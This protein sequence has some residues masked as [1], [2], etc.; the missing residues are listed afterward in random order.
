MIIKKKYFFNTLAIAPLVVFPSLVLTACSLETSTKYFAEVIVSGTSSILKDKS[1]NQFAYEGWMNFM[2]NK[3][4]KNLYGDLETY[5]LDGQWT[6]FKGIPDINSNSTDFLQGNGLWRRGGST[7]ETTL[8][9]I[10]KGGANLVITPGF[11]FQESVQSV[12]KTEKNKGF[13]LL[14]GDVDNSVHDYFNVSTFSFRSEQSGFLSGIAT[15]EFLKVNKH[16]FN[17]KNEPGGLKAGGFVGIGFPSTMDFL[18]GF[19]MGIIAHNL[20]T[21]DPT[22]KVEWVGFDNKSGY[23]TGSFAVGGGT[24]KIKELIKKGVDAIIP[25]AGAQSADAIA[26]IETNTDSRPIVM[27]GVDSAQENNPNLNKNI[28]KHFFKNNNKI[29]SA[30]GKNEGSQKIIQFSAVKR[31]DI[32]TYF[33]LA[34]IF[35]KNDPNN[36]SKIFKKINSD[37]SRTSSSD[38]IPVGGF[39]FKNMGTYENLTTGVSDAGLPYLKLYDNGKWVTENSGKLMFNPNGG[40]YNNTAYKILEEKALLY[41]GNLTNVTEQQLNDG[42]VPSVSKDPVFFPLNKDSSGNLINSVIPSLTITEKESEKS[43]EDL[44]TN[45]LNGSKWH[46]YKNN[47]NNSEKT[48]VKKEEFNL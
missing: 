2:N 16:I 31:L 1:F 45:V 29:L 6:N 14:D 21:T 3:Q 15:A 25:I 8:K 18:A 33:I 9:W 32:A 28:P 42:T 13:I 43:E 24:T 40:V 34:A 38:N 5:E 44:K 10:F 7:P 20:K 35:N 4:K 46:P 30:D 12:A 26:A 47:K 27:I 11:D 19:Q 36:F 48:I 17:E 37:K 41:K 39:G 22:E 23:E